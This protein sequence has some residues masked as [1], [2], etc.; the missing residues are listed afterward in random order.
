MLRK[1]EDGFKDHIKDLI[2]DKS[3]KRTLEL[4]KHKITEWLMNCSFDFKE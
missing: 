1:L 2:N 3:N 4:T